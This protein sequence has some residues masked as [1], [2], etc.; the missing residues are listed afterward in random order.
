MRFHNQIKNRILKLQ[1]LVFL[2]LTTTLAFAD[3]F[4]DDLPPEFGLDDDPEP[5]AP[6]DVYIPIMML[7][8]LVSLFVYFYKNR[9]KME[10]NIE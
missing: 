1:M 10:S 8:M 7:I 9:A 3:E 4:Y 6:I 5:G 2:L